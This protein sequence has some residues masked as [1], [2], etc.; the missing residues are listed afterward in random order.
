[1]RAAARHDDRVRHEIEVALDQIAA[2]RRQLRQR[3]RLA[4]DRRAAGCPSRKSARNCGHVSSPGPRK[5]V[6]ACARRF[7]RQRRHVQAAEHDV[8][9]SR[10]VVIGQAIRAV[11]RRDVDLNHDEFRVV[12]ESSRSTCSS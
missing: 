11:R 3:P 12:V 5:I 2:D 1:M 8:C 10:A 9:T 6:S 7:V 4:T